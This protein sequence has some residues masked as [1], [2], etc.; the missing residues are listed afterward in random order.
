M[1]HSSGVTGV[2]IRYI[3]CQV[4]QHSVRTLGTI[5]KYSCGNRT[6]KDAKGTSISLGGNLIRANPSMFCPPDTS[7][8]LPHLNAHKQTD[9][10]TVRQDLHNLLS[11]SFHPLRPHCNDWSMPEKDLS[12]GLP[13]QRV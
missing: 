5:I 9:R 7:T 10:N 4:L 13:V 1:L 12:E 3:K 8:A 2:H 6:Q 11:M